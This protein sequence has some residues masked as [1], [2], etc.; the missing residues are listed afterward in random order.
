MSKSEAR[1]LEAWEWADKGT[2]LAKTGLLE[3]AIPCYQ[4]ALRINPNYAEAHQNLGLAYYYLNRLEESVEEYKQ[5]LRIDPNYAK[6]HDSLGQTYYFLNR[7][8]E[9]VEEYK[10]ALRIDP[11]YAEAHNNLGVSY[12]AQGKFEEAI[13][14]YRQA[15]RLNPNYTEAHCNLGVVY[16]VQGKLDDATREYQRA[17]RINPNHAGLHNNLAN[18]HYER[19][20]IDQAITEYQRALQIDPNKFDAYYNLAVAYEAAGKVR[21]A[22]GCYQRFIELAPAQVSSLVSKAKE[23]MRGL[24]ENTNKSDSDREAK[25][26]V[27]AHRL[28][29]PDDQDLMERSSEDPTGSA[30]RFRKDV[31]FYPTKPTDRSLRKGSASEGKTGETLTYDPET[32]VPYPVLW[33]AS[34]RAKKAG[35]GAPALTVHIRDEDLRRALKEPDNWEMVCPK[36][37]ER[38]SLKIF[39]D[40]GRYN[41]VDF[42]ELFCPCGEVQM[43]LHRI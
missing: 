5:A 41:P 42:T 21:E 7:L 16:S 29:L 40:T 33:V 23:S 26:G 38:V 34:E 24:A 36:C 43:M 25:P 37:N 19:R 32:K 3:E 1:P 15:L 13:T 14:E 20:E 28:A 9:S 11:N 6:A 8:E 22:I 31:Y 35:F 4:Q 18:I 12:R 17:L 30:G 2:S 10:Q 27:I 39:L